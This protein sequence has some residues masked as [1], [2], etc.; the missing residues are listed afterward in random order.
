MSAAENSRAVD[1]RAVA[2]QLQ[3]VLVR[4]IGLALHGKQAHWHV[5]GRN[6]TPVHEQLDTLVGDARSYADEVAERLVALGVPV[7]GR[8]QAVA[9]SAGTFPEGFLADDKIVALIVDEI[10]KV[11]EQARE[12][13][14]E[15]EDIDL[16]SQDLAIEIVRVFEKHRWMFDAQKESG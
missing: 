2:T 8:P 9:E 14:D 10:E 1:G 4:L 3:P 5:V 7:D 6:F 15:L 12:A 11:I 16:I 13:M